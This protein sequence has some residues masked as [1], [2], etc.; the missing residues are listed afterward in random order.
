MR[1]QWP[2]AAPALVNAMAAE[3]LFQIEQALEQSR[4]LVALSCRQIARAFLAGA[5]GSHWRENFLRIAKLACKEGQHELS[6]CALLAEMLVE[7]ADSS[8][9]NASANAAAPAGARCQRRQRLRAKTNKGEIVLSE[10]W[11][12]RSMQGAR[13]HIAH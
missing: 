11:Q 2:R 8:E 3:S 4:P 12:G 10:F 6:C 9:A 5:R 7:A 13:K 1:E